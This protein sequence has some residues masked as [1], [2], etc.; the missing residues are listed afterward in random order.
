[1]LFQ[2]GCFAQFGPCSFLAGADAP[3]ATQVHAEKTAQLRREVQVLAPRTPGVYGMI[4]ARG[5]LFYVGKAKNLRARLLSYFRPNS[6]DAK[7]GKIINQAVSISWENWPHELAALLR[8]LELIR[9]WRPGWNVRGQPW[10]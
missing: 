3:I 9:R 6:R 10:R 8:E 1:M 5:D 2:A 7:A 4:N